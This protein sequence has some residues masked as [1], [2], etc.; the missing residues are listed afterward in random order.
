MFIRVLLQ[1]FRD[2]QGAEHLRSV[3]CL[4]ASD[5]MAT[6]NPFTARE[7]TADQSV[8]GLQAGESRLGGEAKP[9]LGERVLGGMHSAQAMAFLVFFQ[10]CRHILRC[11]AWDDVSATL[12]TSVSK[13][14]HEFGPVPER[15]G[16]PRNA[17]FSPC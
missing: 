3:C 12:L 13:S 5:S 9:S 11:K 6:P 15:L 8:I 7:A 4:Q 10:G 2:A 14:C 1:D 16:R 17:F